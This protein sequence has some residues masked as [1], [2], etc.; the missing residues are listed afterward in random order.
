MLSLNGLVLFLPMMPTNATA[1]TVAPMIT[2]C[3]LLLLPSSP[4]PV[5]PEPVGRDAEYDVDVIVYTCVP[6]VVTV[7]TGTGTDVVGDGL[8][9]FGGSSE[10]EVVV[11]GLLLLLSLSDVVG[12]VEGT[13]VVTAVGS[14]FPSLPP[15]L[16]VSE[17][18]EEMVSEGGVVSDGGGASVVVPPPPG[19]EE[20]DGGGGSVVVGP[21]SDVVDGGLGYCQGIV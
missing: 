15:P 7:T 21:G 19:L 5:L 12:G 6:D 8:V 20:E 18:E 13:D 1:P 17:G 2:A 10:A 3:W 11:V 4:P 9:L 16:V 14:W